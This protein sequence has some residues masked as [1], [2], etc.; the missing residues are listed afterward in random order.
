MPFM[1]FLPVFIFQTAVDVDDISMVELHVKEYTA[2]PT[3]RITIL[4]YG[5]G[6][7]N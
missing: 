7:T 5:M 4:I 6:L 2:T 3:V 1:S